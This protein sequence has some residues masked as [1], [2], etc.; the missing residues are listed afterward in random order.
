MK[1]C[2]TL[3][4]FSFSIFNLGSST[5]EYGLRSGLNFAAHSVRPLTFKQFK[6]KGQ[7]LRQM[8]VSFVFASP[9]YEKAS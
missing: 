4:I 3:Y 2:G 1:I 6:K 9:K 5:L 7:S 8:S